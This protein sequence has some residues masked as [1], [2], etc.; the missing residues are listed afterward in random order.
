MKKIMAFA[1]A[2]AFVVPVMADVNVS[3]NTEFF[4]SSVDGEQTLSGGDQIV[5]FSGSSET[6]N[7]YTVSGSMNILASGAEEDTTVTTDGGESI[8]L[9]GPFGSISVG[10]VA[11]GL[12]NVGDYSDMA[13]RDG[14]FGADGAD[15]SVLYVLPALAEGVTV[16]ASFSPEGDNFGGSAEGDSY[17]VAYNFGNGEVYAGTLSADGA[18]DMSAYGIRAGMSGA[19][20]AYEMGSQG[21]V[22]FTGMAASY[23]IG[24]T[25]IIMEVQEETGNAAAADDADQSIVALTHNMG[26]G[27]SVYIQQTQDDATDTDTAYAGMIYAF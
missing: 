10:D 20:F 17:S 1:V 8:S 9:A 27:L 22:D 12:D 23:A 13:P 3:V 25:T 26:G 21:D 11:S 14:G 16:S 24:E 6:S 15:H 5:S 2:S 7:G 19:T 18:D 4:M